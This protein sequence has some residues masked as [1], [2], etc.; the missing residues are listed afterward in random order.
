MRHQPSARKIIS[1]GRR[2]GRHL[3][4]RRATL[5]GI[6]WKSVNPSPIRLGHRRRGREE[7][8]EDLKAEL[9]PLIRAM[10]EGFE[11]TSWSA[12]TRLRTMGVYERQPNGEN[13]VGDLVLLSWSISS[14]VD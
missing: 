7:R 8:M 11:N 2:P 1:A 4:D 12:M 13:I 9:E 3:L 6:R 5:A 10:K 14:F